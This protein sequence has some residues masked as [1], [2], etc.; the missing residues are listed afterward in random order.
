METGEETQQ[1]DEDAIKKKK[2]E[3]FEFLKKMQE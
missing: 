1:M 3:K 2:E